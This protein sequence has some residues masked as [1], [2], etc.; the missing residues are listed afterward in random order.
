M[1][2]STQR[3]CSYLGSVILFTSI[4]GC[5]G[6]ALQSGLDPFA[7][8]VFKEGNTV[9]PLNPPNQSTLTPFTYLKRLFSN[10]LLI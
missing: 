7:P 4:A 5:A 8:M 3:F 6:D 2:L 10:L 9:M 1:M